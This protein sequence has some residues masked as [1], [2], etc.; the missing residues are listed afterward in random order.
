MFAH[1]VLFKVGTGQQQA[2]EGMA[3]TFASIYATCPNCT[4]VTFLGDEDSGEYGS[5]SL[6]DSETALA[7]YQQQAGPQLAAA[8][9]DFAQGPPIIRRFEVYDPKF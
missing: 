2:A 4:Q 9:Q 8:L 5:I 6:W 1:L 3:D 7:A